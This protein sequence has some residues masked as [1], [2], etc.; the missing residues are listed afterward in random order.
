MNNMNADT[1]L[2]L[3]GRTFQFY[4]YTFFGIIIASSLFLGICISLI[5]FSSLMFN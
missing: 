5:V 4:N 2:E 1:Y 3:I